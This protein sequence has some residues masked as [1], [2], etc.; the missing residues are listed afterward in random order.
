MAKAT[1]PTEPTAGEIVAMKSADVDKATSGEHVKVFTVP[2]GPKPTE[3]NGFSHEANKA[4]VVQYMLS[5]GMRPTGDVRVASIELHSNGQ[6]WNITYAV[7]ARPASELEASE[8]TRPEDD[9]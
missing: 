5:Q 9:K 6:S 2:A 7:P 1:K 3:A 4:A 8:D